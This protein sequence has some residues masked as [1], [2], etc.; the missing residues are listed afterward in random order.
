M[1][2]GIGEHARIDRAVVVLLAGKLTS[3][4]RQEL[5]L[6]FF[7]GERRGVELGRI[8]DGH[9]KLQLWPLLQRLYKSSHPALCYRVQVRTA[10]VKIDAVHLVPATEEL[11]QK[12]K[13]RSRDFCQQA[14]D[15]L[16][17]DGTDAKL[18]IIQSAAH[19]QRKIDD[20]VSILEER[21]C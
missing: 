16:P 18:R 14:H 13:R 15:C 17:D 10:G 5:I 3:L 4:H 19:R 11:S 7:R 8:A 2:G 6:Q 20:A 21:D 9:V 12:R 1:L